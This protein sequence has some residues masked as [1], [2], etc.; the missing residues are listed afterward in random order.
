MSYKP[1]RWL[2]FCMP[3]KQYLRCTKMRLHLAGLATSV[4]LASSAL[5]L[6][7]RLRSLVGTKKVNKE[8]TPGNVVLVH[9]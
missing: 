5:I 7:G 1:L 3:S 9:A 8:D 6:G 4:A 2:S